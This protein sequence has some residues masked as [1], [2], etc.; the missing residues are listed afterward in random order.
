MNFLARPAAAAAPKHINPT[1]RG[2]SHLPT[3]CNSRLTMIGPH[4]QLHQSKAVIRRPNSVVR[5][6]AASSSLIASENYGTISSQIITI[7]V[8]YNDLLYERE[9]EHPHHQ[10]HATCWAKSAPTSPILNRKNI[11]N[12]YRNSLKVTPEFFVREVS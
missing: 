8:S 5:R 2:S 7:S 10:L 4:Q 12:G 11:K 3:Y 1:D 9:E 6:P